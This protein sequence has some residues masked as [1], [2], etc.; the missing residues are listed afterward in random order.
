M[1]FWNKIEKPAPDA[2]TPSAAPSMPVTPPPAP[3]ASSAPPVPPAPPAA[4]RTE[5]AA[6]PTEAASPSGRSEGLRLGRGVRLEGKLTFSGTVRVD[7]TFQGS[8]VTDG[9]LVVGAGAKVDAEISCGTVL[10]EGEVNGNVSAKEA[11]ELR[12][13]ATLRGDVQSPSLAIERGAVFQGTS[14]R[15]AASA[16]PGR[17]AAAPAPSAH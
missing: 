6:R 2:A 17:A 9:V 10:V 11:V 5:P 1:S 12:R 3:A 14:R 13:G 8:I 15:T 4:A 7:A 16:S